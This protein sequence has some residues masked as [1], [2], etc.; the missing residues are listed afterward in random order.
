MEDRGVFR[1]DRQDWHAALAGFGDQ[2]RTGNHESFLVRQGEGFAR[3]D[4]PERCRQSGRADDGGYDDVYFVVTGQIDH[5]AFA[6]EDLRGVFTQKILQLIEAG[7][8]GEG[9]GMRGEFLHLRCQLFHLAIG[10]ERSR[11]VGGTEMAN[12]IERATA[13]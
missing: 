7:L 12:D 13:D 8:I 10:S 11:A 2:E 3:A 6:R 5:A 4:S 1:I 9:N